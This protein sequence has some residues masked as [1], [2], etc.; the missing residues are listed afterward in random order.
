[1]S[2]TRWN[3]VR[4][5]EAAENTDHVT[6]EHLDPNT[7]RLRGNQ[8]AIL[9]T[10]A[11]PYRDDIPRAFAAKMRWRDVARLLGLS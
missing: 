1:M 10:R 8:V 2:T 11:G 7:I 9:V 3:Q 6:V 5:L 4:I